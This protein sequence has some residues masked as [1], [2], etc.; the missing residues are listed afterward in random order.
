MIAIPVILVV[1]GAVMGFLVTLLTDFSNQRVKQTLNVT[2]QTAV[3]QIES[4]I[5]LSSA[6]LTRVD[7]STYSDPYGPSG[8][9]ASWSYV[10]S[11]A[12]ARTLILQTYATDK[13]PLAD[14]RNPVYKG[15]GLACSGDAL[16]ANEVLSNTII[17][18]IKNVSGVNI[19]YRRVLTNTSIPRCGG[20]GAAFQVQSCPIGS[21]NSI[22][23]VDDTELLRNVSNFNLNYYASSTSTN[24]VAPN[25]Y[26]PVNY[27]ILNGA[28]TVLV[29]FTHTLDGSP[30]TNK[31]S[32][33]ITRLN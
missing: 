3:Q 19:L 27:N 8:N 18:F 5:K 25:V 30:I 31:V 7:T 11:S 28:T 14:I 22:C 12:T 10:G 33:R 21:S 4:D 26:S 1:M 13:N 9:A 29:D 24:A 20:A 16:Y 6:F 17:Y 32:I 15:S 2:G 23:R